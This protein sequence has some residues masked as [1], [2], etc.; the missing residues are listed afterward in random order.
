M[1][2][3]F[4][5]LLQLQRDLYNIPRGQD[6]FRV[7]LETILRADASD[8]KL[9]PLVAMNPMGKEHIP[10]ILD[11]LLAM[12]ADAVADR[13]IAQM[14]DRFEE[15]SGTF[16]L[17]LVVADDLMGG[18]TN[19]YTSEFSTRFETEQSLKRG[20][21][22]GILWTSEV[23]SIQKVHEVT[24]TAAYRA[25]YIQRYGFARTLQEMLNQEGYAMAMAGCRQSNLD[26]DDL[27]YTREIVA[28]YL[29]TQDYPTIVTCLFGDR[30]ARSLGY[31][32]Q[33]LSEYAG[34]ALALHQAQQN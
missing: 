16:K 18:W 28:P 2:L 10:A 14:L 27:A 7:Y 22:S 32:P 5:P 1:K 3:K 30:A 13:A 25:A 21:L 24:L 6:R 19:R 9:L 34:L 11:T 20:W 17:G 31:I 4:I 15:D 29:S 8:V 33:G 23:P 12:D 26:A